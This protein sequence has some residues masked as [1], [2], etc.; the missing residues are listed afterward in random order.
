MTDGALSV[1]DSFDKHIFILLGPPGAGK[2]TVASRLVPLMEAEH[3]S[4]GDLLRSAA[5]DRES[6]LGRQVASLMSR[7][8]LVPDQTMTSILGHALRRLSAEKIL[9]DGF[10]RTTVQARM[11]E[12]ELAG[13]NGRVGAAMLLEVG[14]QTLVE[15]IS[16]RL[17]CGTCDKVYHK[18]TLPPSQQGICDQCGSDLKR[19]S[20]DEPATIRNRL[21]L[22]REKTAPL[23][24]WYESRGQLVRVDGEGVVEQI[25]A[26]AWQ[27][28]RSDKSFA[29][30]GGANG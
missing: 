6:S 30:P 24:D 10:P 29:G 17:V 3:L 7:G 28:L 27:A 8:E 23:I 15:R 14:D 20:D 1:E 13:I 18:V 2:G 5:L 4:T 19:R 11:L 16:G 26:R 9:L 21:A 22:Y 25:V 12:E